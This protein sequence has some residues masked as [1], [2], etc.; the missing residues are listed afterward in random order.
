MN[1]CKAIAI[2][3]LLIF[4]VSHL[5]FPQNVQFDTSGLL[6]KVS[7]TKTLISYKKIRFLGINWLKYNEEYERNFD[8]RNVRD[9]ADIDKVVKK[10]LRN[11]LIEKIEATEK[12]LEP[13]DGK[14]DGVLIFIEKHWAADI[15]AYKA[16]LKNLKDYLKNDNM[17]AGL[18]VSKIAGIESPI[19]ANLFTN[20]AIHT[21]ET[22]A[23]SLQNGQL[24][25]EL[26]RHYPLNKFVIELYNNSV[27]RNVNIKRITL[28]QFLK[29]NAF[30]SRQYQL[31]DSLITNLTKA[32]KDIDL[33]LLRAI[34]Q[35]HTP[36]SGNAEYV[37]LLELLNSQW[38]QQW[39]WF[40]GGQLRLNPLDFTTEAFVKNNPQYDAT[41]AAAFDKYIDAVIEKYMQYD[42]TGKVDDF[43]KILSLKGTGKEVF[44]LADKIKALTD[45]NKAAIANLQQTSRV[46]NQVIVPK[47]GDYYS[48]SAIEEVKS[49]NNEESYLKDLLT[50]DEVKKIALHNI[51]ADRKGGTLIKITASPDQSEV[52]KIT[53]TI[54][55]L[56]IQLA[57]LTTQFTP[58]AP[59]LDYFTSKKAGVTLPK[60]KDISVSPRGRATFPEMKD[61]LKGILDVYYFNQALYD[62]VLADMNI[63]DG[64][65]YNED[66]QN[67]RA[68]AKAFLD[69]YARRA[70]ERFYPILQEDSLTLAIMYDFAVNSTLPLP[71]LKESSNKQPLYHSEVLT[72]PA[73][74][75][76]QKEEITVFTTKAEK[77]TLKLPSFAYERGKHNRFQLS[78]GISYT[79]MDITQSSVKEENGQIIVTNNSQQYRFTAGV[80]VHLGNGLVLKDNRFLGRFQERSSV[81]LG[82]G[83]PKP[84]ENIYL[85]YSYDLLPGLKTIVGC[86]FYKHNKYEILNNTII[87]EKLRYKT[88]FPFVAIQLDPTGVLK[89]LNVFK[90]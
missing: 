28:Q 23:P 2:T 64:D 36:L 26:R 58:Y 53:D 73:S 20:S 57:A 51:P 19:K 27:A 8:V 45:A 59:L 44:S 35:F 75:E 48:L 79:F 3:G 7:Y 18:V 46:L 60:P 70:A 6:L 42:T 12:I 5:S 80:H 33:E 47:D 22:P 63:D 1:H 13:A 83:I 62:Q 82:V 89:A 69:E 78:A 77:D 88:A 67:H 49:D 34:N 39:F 86:H 38:A 81:Y 54:G 61:Y 11:I 90:N 74:R 40:R 14:K 71:S 66:D 55:G 9:Q 85:G 15:A 56:A 30:V 68:K 16:D 87:D 4:F 25:F 29:Y 65:P 37:A 10:E 52:Q 17:D 21:F 43:K 31:V 84:L 50:E 76:A 41:K 24:K 72:T 32:G